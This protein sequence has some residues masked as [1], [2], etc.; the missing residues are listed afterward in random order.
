MKSSYHFFIVLL[1]ILVASCTK[2]PIQGC[3]DANSINYNS[4]ATEDDGSCFYQGS[5]LLWFN[6]TVYTTL[7]GQGIGSLIIT[8]NGEVVSSAFPTSAFHSSAPSCGDQN[9][10]VADVDLGPNQTDSVNY[11]VTDMQNNTLWS[12]TLGITANECTAEQLN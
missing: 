1:V 7:S 6:Q 9:T 3:T 12:G 10:I 8:A 11:V 5:M 4:E 2:D